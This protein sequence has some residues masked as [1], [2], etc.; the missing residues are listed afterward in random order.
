MTSSIP[1]RKPR[2]P[3]ARPS[4][5]SPDPSPFPA[6]RPPEPVMWQAGLGAGVIG[7]LGAL[8]LAG[9]KPSE[10]VILVLVIGAVIERLASGW[11]ARNRVTPS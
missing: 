10:T 9:I 2:T 1:P 8:V 6:P 7:V 11:W 4:I 3:V 5:T